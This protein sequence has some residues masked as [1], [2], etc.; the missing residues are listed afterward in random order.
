MPFFFTVFHILYSFLQFGIPMFCKFVVK[1]HECKRRQDLF[2]RHKH[3]KLDCL[4][5]ITEIHITQSSD[6]IEGIVI[7]SSRMK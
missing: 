4:F 2:I 1:M 6:K 7:T 5:E 3:I